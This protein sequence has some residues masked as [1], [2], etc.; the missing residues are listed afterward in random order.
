MNDVE[1]KNNTANKTSLSKEKI[2]QLLMVLASGPLE[3]ST[4]I[5]ASDYDWK[6][7]H[8]FTR[9]QLNKLDDFTKR[10]SKTIPHKFANL[11]TG[12]FVVTI[13]SVTQ[14]FADKFLGEM[15]DS[16]QDDYYLAFGTDSE[17]MAGVIGIPNQTAITWATQLLGDTESEQDDTRDLSLLEESLLIDI[18]S[19]IVESMAETHSG[20]Q[21]EPA[22][23][24]VRRLMPLE[25]QGTEELCKINLSV[26][27]NNTDKTE[28]YLLILSK[29]LESVVGKNELDA[30]E[31]SKEDI[32]NAILDRL[33]KM[34]VSV[35][36]QLAS[37]E[38]SLKGLMGLNPGDI[39]LLDKMTD[40][41]IKVII[42]GQPVLNAQAV[43]CTGKNA[44]LITERII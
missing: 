28:A 4:M 14:H 32:S 36:A 6:Q 30:S 11:V 15:L 31:F 13:D 34:P 7:P 40:E 3:D 9:E 39:L 37:T 33:Q 19:A 16:K 35:T 18:A 12:E 1:V 41:P 44:V 42:E 17:N 43:R 24:I 22:K 25:L 8:Y 27:R 5:N 38:I 20:C 2:Q 10:L 29:S 23:N 21:F 26:T